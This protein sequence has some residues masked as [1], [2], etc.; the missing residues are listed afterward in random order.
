MTHKYCLNYTLNVR[1]SVKM[2]PKNLRVPE[3]RYELSQRNL[4]TTGLKAVL[5]SRLQAALD[6]EQHSDDESEMQIDDDDEHEVYLDA[7]D[8]ENG[9]DDEVYYD[10]VDTI[11]ISDEGSENEN[12]IRSDTG[13]I[14]DDENGRPSNTTASGT[15]QKKI[16]FVLMTGERYKS[17]V[18]FSVEEN[19]FYRKNK[20][21]KS[22]LI[23][24][25]CAQKHKN[26]CNLHVYLD[27]AKNE[28]Y[29]ELPQRAHGHAT[30][31][32]LYKKLKVLNAIKADCARP[33]ILV[34]SNAK[35]SASKAIFMKE[36][37]Q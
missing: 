12:D 11:E 36:I 13:D 28:C 21:L 17:E 10:I 37:Q 4:D 23:S 3:L 16:D 35:T 27:P 5:V 1:T 8:S 18:L 6:S 20:T 9:N 15:A 29:Q 24:Y 31:G 25:D 34:N 14:S 33:D 19:Q 2:D 22:G 7:S 30:Q 26:S 32:D